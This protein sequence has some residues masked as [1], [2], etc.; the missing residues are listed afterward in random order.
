MEDNQGTA[1]KSHHF[2]TSSSAD[3]HLFVSYY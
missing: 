3:K 1:L 2:M